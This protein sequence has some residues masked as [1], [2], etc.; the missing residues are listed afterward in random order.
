MATRS[1]GMSG[2]A[3][4]E[5]ETRQ[6]WQT[7][8]ETAGSSG[9]QIVAKQQHKSFREDPEYA[10]LEKD[11]HSKRR[12]V[13]SRIDQVLEPLLWNYPDM[14]DAINEVHEAQRERD[15]AWDALI[16]RREVLVREW[17]K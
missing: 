6:G 4:H 17:S 12:Y 3:W 5:A 9:G 13:E 14:T 15:T 11:F 7:H 8:E 2:I 16:K 1:L 10:G